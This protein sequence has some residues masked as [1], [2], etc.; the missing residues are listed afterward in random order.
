MS[1]SLSASSSVLSSSE[2]EVSKGSSLDARCERRFEWNIASGAEDVGA[3]RG[4]IV[5]FVK[6]VHLQKEV[7]AVIK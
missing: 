3:S 5:L 1:L 6:Q 7:G 2:G 4:I